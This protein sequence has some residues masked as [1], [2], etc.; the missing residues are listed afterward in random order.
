MAR[1]YSVAAAAFALEVA[2][3]WLDNFLSQHTV[4]GVVAAERGV[5]RRIPLSALVLVAIAR[6]LQRELGVGLGRGLDA[7]RRLVESDGDSGLL[8]IGDAGVL[9]VDVAALRRAIEDRLVIAMEI[10]VAPRR[11]R[12]PAR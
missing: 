4:P 11:G 3:R 10:L 6:D 7:A 1:A 8:P 2:P 5:A 9:R 12:P